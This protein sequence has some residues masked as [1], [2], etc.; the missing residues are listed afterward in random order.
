MPQTPVIIT[1][2]M[3]GNSSQNTLRSGPFFFSLLDTF[4]HRRELIF[5]VAG[6]GSCFVIAEN[7]SSFVI[8]GN[9]CSFSS[10]ETEAHVCGGFRTW[11]LTTYSRFVLCTEM[12]NGSVG[13]K[14]K[15]TWRRIGEP[16][17]FMDLH[18]KTGLSFLKK[19][20]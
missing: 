6:N 19:V 5:S 15:A 11:K 20:F 3:Q 7:G 12:A 2:Q 9:G 14:M 8:Y 16:G 1:K 13:W 10:A 4:C 18:K 17:Q